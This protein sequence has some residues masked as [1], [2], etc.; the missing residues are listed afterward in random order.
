MVDHPIIMSA[1]MANALRAGRKTQTRRVLSRRN[2]MLDGAPWSLESW[3]NRDWQW[4]DSWVD[5]GP[6]PAGNPGPYL[7]VPEKSQDTVH[8]VY[9]RIF[10]DDRMWVR[11]AHY[12]TDN[13]HD[14]Y[15]VPIAD[16]QA[17]REHI[18]DI[19]RSSLTT[20]MKKAQLR[21]RPS[22]HMPRWASRLTL[23]VTDVR[24][25]RL[26]EISADDAKA[27]GLATVTKDD[28]M[29]KY[30]IPDRDGL[31]GNDDHGWPWEEWEADPRR[32]FRKLW[33]RI[34]AGT[35]HMW[36]HNPLVIPYTFHVS[37]RNIDRVRVSR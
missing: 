18:A 21:A 31:P 4:A 10:R 8:R 20:E 2:T 35:D 11:E 37:D 13:G 32:A 19:E 26:Q 27:E 16:A 15:A 36:D 6:S 24:V 7:K 33:D 12:L 23:T 3:E 34:H 1:P 30:G 22:I 5:P 9:P 17:V 25:Q 28:K 29:W 14:E